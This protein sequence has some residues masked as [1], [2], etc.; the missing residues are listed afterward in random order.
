MMG[1]KQHRAPKLF[2][3]QIDL[4]SRVGPD[5]P[6]RRVAETVDFSFVRKEVAHLY[7]GNGNMSVDP[8]VVIKLMFLLFFEN[9][10][11]ERQLMRQLP[12]RLD[13]LWFCQYDLD[14]DTP[15]H[16]ILSK[17]RRRWGPEVFERF[18]EQ[19]LAQCIDAGLVDGSIIHIDSCLI[20]ANASK[21]KLRPE[22]R[23]LSQEVCQ[24]LD[25]TQTPENEESSPRNNADNDHN[26]NKRVSPVDPDARLVKKYGQTTL[27]YKDNRVVDDRHGIITATIT[28]PANVN[29]S[30][31]LTEAIDS[32]ESNT[33]LEVKTTVADKG[34]GNGENYQHLQDQG[35]TACISHQRY[36]KSQA[37]DFTSDKF[38]Y[39]A[40]ADC[41]WCP[42]GHALQRK[43]VKKAD[44]VV[45]YQIDRAVCQG[46]PDCSKCA[47]GETHGRQI[48]RS[49]YAPCY[50]WAD[51]CLSLSERKRLM[52][53]R[54]AKAEGSFADA[55]NNHG[56]KRS[57]W[58]G[59]TMAGIQNQMIAAVQNLRKLLRY[60]RPRAGVA[61]V[62]LILMM[63]QTHLADSFLTL[64][65]RLKFLWSTMSKYSLFKRAYVELST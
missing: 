49:S 31:T 56:Y 8:I 58:R 26:L 29:D 57:R 54:K 34:Y 24:K 30:K 45:I 42:A 4:D 43:Y 44:D 17:A 59:L 55:A 16:S 5:H 27:G 15:N 50:E 28:T 64:G 3:S 60:R 46:C 20:D 62:A 41:Y 25:D 9:V 65:W 12:L 53:R 13:W 21:D 35:I 10:N 52:S 11:S 22:L 1:H 39:D 48:Q 40:A 7:G 38:F 47:T 33:G 37:D 19:V 36:K 61:S 6:L 18:F 14:D 32:H 51:S 23:L 63:P 2:Y